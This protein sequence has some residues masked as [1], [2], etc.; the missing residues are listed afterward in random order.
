MNK[1]F[2]VL[3]LLLQYCLGSLKTSSCVTVHDTQAMGID[4]KKSQAVCISMVIA[5]LIYVCEQDG[6]IPG[7][8]G[9]QN[10]CTPVM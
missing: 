2:A 9:A 5:M 3:L 7:A 8:A 10:K 4:S 1:V 6:Q